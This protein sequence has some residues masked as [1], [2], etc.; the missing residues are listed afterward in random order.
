MEELRGP[1]FIL[2]CLLL[3]LLYPLFYAVE[4][5]AGL[6]DLQIANTK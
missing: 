3:V 6:F 4:M 1:A 5:I 2:I